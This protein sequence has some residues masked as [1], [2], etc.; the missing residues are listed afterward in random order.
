MR[1]PS[2]DEHSTFLEDDRGMSDALAVGM[3]LGSALVLAA[4]LAVFM[5]AGG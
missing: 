3:L 2:P 5:L 1:I 4:A